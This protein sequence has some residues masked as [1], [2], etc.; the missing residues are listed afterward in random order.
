MTEEIKIDKSPLYNKLS[1][2]LMPD[3]LRMWRPESPMYNNFAVNKE[4]IDELIDLACDMNL[5]YSELEEE[6]WISIHAW[7]ILCELDASEAVEPLIYTFNKYPEDDYSDYLDIELPEVVARLSKGKH[8]KILSNL[9]HDKSKS[10]NS[11]TLSLRVIELTGEYFEPCTSECLDILTHC[12]DESDAE[13]RDFNG[14]IIAAMLD[15]DRQGS[16]IDSIRKAFNADIVDLTMVGD[17]EDVEIKLGLRD[18]R[19][20]PKRNYILERYPQLK[21]FNESNKPPPAKKKKLGRN[22][23]C[24][25]GSGRKY[26]KCCLDDAIDW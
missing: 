10:I 9:L 11:R 19:E 5:Y 2:L 18:K 13:Q 17:L 25:C 4:E 12:L 3:D 14:Y 23:I 6:Y 20:T 16:K 8:L 22:D 7:R 21:L 26:K 24:P 15:L 1:I